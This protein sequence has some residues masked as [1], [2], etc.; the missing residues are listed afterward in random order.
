M[1]SLLHDVLVSAPA[2]SSN[3][4]LASQVAITN[5]PTVLPLATCAIPLLE[6]TMKPIRIAILGTQGLPANYGGYETFAEQIAT[7]LVQRGDYQVTVY[8][9][10]SKAA[11]RSMSTYRG[12]R[13]CH[14]YVPIKGGFG[15]LLFDVACLWDSLG[16]YDIIYMLGYGA[17]P[18]FPLPRLFGA[19]MWVNLDGIEWK[20]SKWPCYIRAYVRAAE[21]FCGQSAN[22][23]ICDAEAIESYYQKAFYST[24]A[25]TFIPYGADLPELNQESSNLLPDDL[26]QFGYYLLVAR[27]EPENLIQE[28]VAGYLAS[29]DH[30]PLVVVGGLNERPYVMS[31]LG[32]K[33]DRVRFLG[34]VYEKDK[35]NALRAFAFAAFHGHTVGGT[36]PSLLEAMAAGRPIFAHDNPFN[37][38]VGGDLLGYF[39]GPQDIPGLIGSLNGRTSIQDG[40]FL[41]AC[42]QRLLKRYSWDAVAAAYDCLAKTELGRI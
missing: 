26:T 21:W 8:C 40:N 41:D 32:Q 14:L 37:R 5:P 17:A 38:E 3:E 10:V 19:R 39:H 11:L 15:N 36:N 31:L 7:R 25:T 42:R 18:F 4:F 34:G 29:S 22:Q 6:H 2:D 24:A 12:V 30:R 35:L 13:L 20:R 16:E 33:G 23:V 1:F 27:L 28:I 9:P